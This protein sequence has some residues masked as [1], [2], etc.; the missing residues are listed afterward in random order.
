MRIKAYWV[1]DAFIP[2]KE[3]ELTGTPCEEV[4]HQGKNCFIEP[5]SRN[6][7]PG[8]RTW[9]KTVISAC[10]IFFFRNRDGS[11]RALRPAANE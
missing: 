1:G 4:I 11:Y 9:A 7:F 6:Y 5:D 3:F 10:D 8:K 2:N